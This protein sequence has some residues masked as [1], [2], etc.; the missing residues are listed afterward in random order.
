MWRVG[1]VLYI[2]VSRLHFDVLSGCVPMQKYIYRNN[3]IM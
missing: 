2:F 3:T 1:D